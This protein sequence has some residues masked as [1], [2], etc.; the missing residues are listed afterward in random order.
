MAIVNT[1][2]NTKFSIDYL[3][4]DMDEDHIVIY[5]EKGEVSI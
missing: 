4:N 2:D 1:L 3:T 5:M